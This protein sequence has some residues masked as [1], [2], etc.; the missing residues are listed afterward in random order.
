VGAVS[1][2][3]IKLDERGNI[4]SVAVILGAREVFLVAGEAYRDPDGGFIFMWMTSRYCSSPRAPTPDLE[5]PLARA[6][7][8]EAARK[9]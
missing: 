4:R 9:P 3:C 1:D 5:Q 7:H 8:S 2:A 6:P